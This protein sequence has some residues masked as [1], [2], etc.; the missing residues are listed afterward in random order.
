MF[1]SGAIVYDAYIDGLIKGGN[2][3]KAIEVFQRMK[4]DG[5][6]LSTVT[7]TLMINLYGKV[8]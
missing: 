5:C 1:T 6:Q 7:Y 2:P 8:T 3:Q 4:R